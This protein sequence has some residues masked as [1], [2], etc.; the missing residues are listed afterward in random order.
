MYPN[1]PIRATLTALLIVI[2]CGA[3]R[4]CGGEPAMVQQIK[5]E[6]DKNYHDL[7][8]LYQ[9][10][11]AHPEL[12]LQEQQTAA[13]LAHE[14]QEIGFEVTAKVGGYGLVCFLRNGPG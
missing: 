9:Y 8:S 12:S 6:I 5:A 7:E 3:Q 4:V 13:R 11:H 10:L 2:G 14:M 1:L